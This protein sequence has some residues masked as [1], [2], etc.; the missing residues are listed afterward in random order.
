M[1]HKDYRDVTTDR[2]D[3]TLQEIRCDACAEDYISEYTSG[4]YKSFADYFNS[5][6]SR[7]GLEIPDIITRSN[8]SKN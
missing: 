4:Q 8:I 6:V 1:T 5:Y 7:R 3:K 2:L